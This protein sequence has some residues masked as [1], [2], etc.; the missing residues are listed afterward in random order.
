MAESLRDYLDFAVSVAYSAGRLTLGY[1]QNGVGVDLK[2]D[3]SPVTIAD[4]KAE[5]FIRQCIEK[6]FPDHGIVGEEF[7]KKEAA[8]HSHRW[9]VDPIDGTNSFIHG[10][11]VYAVLIG[12][13]IEGRIEAG[14]AYYPA[15]DEM[16]A[17]ASGEGCWWNGRRAHVSPVERLAD[18]LVVFTDIADFAGY[19]RAAEWERIQRATWRRAGWGDA[20]GYLL[21]ATGRA[22]VMLDPIVEPWDLAPFPVILREAGGF[23]GDW[24]GNS[25]IYGREGMAT[26]EQLLPEVLALLRTP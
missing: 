1:F 6:K 10:V 11:P 12:L 24:R 19:N 7:G 23:F 14:C 9:F 25:T 4:L 15:L 13:E 21:V 22:E 18:G 2:A 17:S 20:Y 8:R 16:L 26:S 3:A 5:E